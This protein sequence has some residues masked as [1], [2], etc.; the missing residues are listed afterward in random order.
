MIESNCRKRLK[1]VKRKCVRIGMII[2]CFIMYW[3]LQI[4]KPMK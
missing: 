3:D 4:R 2:I 1:I